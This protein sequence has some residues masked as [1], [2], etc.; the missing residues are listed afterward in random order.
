[1]TSVL[2]RCG[3]IAPNQTAILTTNTN[4]TLA[5]TTGFFPIQ[6]TYILR[7]QRFSRVVQERHPSPSILT[8]YM[9]ADITS[10]W[11]TTGANRRNAQT[12][13]R[14]PSIPVRRS[15]WCLLATASG[16]PPGDWYQ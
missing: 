1:M 15:P 14:G 11:G 9:L 10:R 16:S 6:N 5:M 4:D 7:V 3:L 2:S 13:D 12:E 8:G